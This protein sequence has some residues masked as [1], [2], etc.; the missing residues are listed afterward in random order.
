MTTSE[1]AA[2]LGLRPLARVHTT[3][4]VGDDPV[5]MLT[6]PI[7]ATAKVLARSG[8]SLADIDV[9]EVNEAFAS[10]PLAWL[11]ETGADA[12]QLNVNGGA[13]ALG[14]PLGCVRGTADDH[15][16]AP[17]GR[18]TGAGT[19][20]RPCARAAAWPTRRS[21]SGSDAVLHSWGQPMWRTT[22]LWLAAGS[23]STPVQRHLVAKAN[24]TASSPNPITRFQFPSA[25]MNGMFC[26]L[27]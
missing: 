12:K 4:V 18:V 11:A 1:T 8:L 2:R 23:R 26:P 14:H 19:G 6:A 3:V 13:I 20:C 17:A 16:R 7:P 21:S 24:P 25:S 10:V 22:A 5:I 9:F 27:M 15:A